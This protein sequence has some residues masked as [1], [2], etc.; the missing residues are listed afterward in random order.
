MPVY[1]G[2]RDRHPPAVLV[3]HTA[4]PPT[5]EEVGE[6]LADIRRLSDEAGGLGRPHSEW[7][8]VMARKRDV[9]AR[10]ETAQMPDTE[11]LRDPF[12][13]PSGL[14]DWTT[15]V[16]A[17]R[18][19][20][21]ILTVELGETPPA[22]VFV[23]FAADVIAA[24]P[25]DNFRLDRDEIWRWIELH[26]ELIETELFLEPPPPACAVLTTPPVPVGDET[27]EPATASA[28]V[29][30]CEQAWSA[31]QHHHPELPDAVIILGSGIERGRLVKLGHW[32]GGRWIADGETRGEV[33]LAGEALHLPPDQVFEVLLHEAAHG[34]NAARGIKDTSRGGRYHNARFAQAAVE[35]GLVASNMPPYGLASTQLADTGQ[36]RYADTISRLG[37]AMRI[38]RHIDRSIGIG[39]ETGTGSETGTSADEDDGPGGGRAK[40]QPAQCGCGRRLRMAPTVLAA[41]PVICGVCDSEFTITPSRSAEREPHTDAVVDR[42]FLERRH[43]AIA[44]E[45]GAP[46]GEHLTA[47]LERER[48]KLD[49]ALAI[50]DNTNEA[51]LAPLRQRRDRIERLLSDR[52]WSLD[53][54]RTNAAT[55]VQADGIRRLLA[56]GT[57]TEVGP[58]ADWYERFATADET[59]IAVPTEDA[60]RCH[61]ELARSMLKADGT[62]T[63]PAVHIAENEFMAGDRLVVE[64]GDGDL[65]LPAG[66]LGTV[67]HVDPAAGELR[68]D[69]A[70]LGRIRISLRDAVVQHIRHDYAEVAADAPAW[71]PEALS[72][73]AQRAALATEP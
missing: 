25:D 44:A 54:I 55:E 4:P 8:Q 65:A 11:L 20:A 72:R 35:V 73:E 71:Q 9:I 1:F 34:L 68:V 64:A 18:L 46:T 3:V 53:S 19:A 28:L 27:V 69:F 50:T 52:G 16:G 42:T 15:S 63:G 37:E 23:P 2:E 49:A 41:G 56:G 67:E 5:T 36:E 48:A 43:A 66:A 12:G 60:R 61:V 29:E 33:L 30:A 40:V 58:L 7:D 21:A 31:I 57:E 70:T 24:V 62:L 47:V 14:F 13:G 38:A 45:P 6:L 51:A 10:I 22:V 59:P 26:R 17:A 39:A 32:W